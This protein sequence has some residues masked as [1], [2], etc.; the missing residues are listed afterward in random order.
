LRVVETRLASSINLLNGRFKVEVRYR[1]Q[2]DNNSEG[3][4]VG[5]SLSSS[6]TAQTAV[7][8]FGDPLVVELMVRLSDARPFRNNIDVYFGGIS[9]IAFTIKVTDLLTGTSR[10]YTKPAGQLLGG[11]DRGTFTAGVTGSTERMMQA[12][13]SGVVRPLATDTVNLLNGRYAVRMRYRNQ[14][15]NPATT[16]YMLGQSIAS[17]PTT[18]TAVFFFNSADVAEWLVRFSDARPFAER[19]DVFHGGL[20][21]IEYTIEVTDTQTGA[22]KEYPKPAFS[23][24]GFVDRQTFR[25]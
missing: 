9:D 21:D 2:F 24:L 14:F 23:F 7:F 17:S 6:S 5:E 10:E 15:A 12:M 22:T 4:L 3:S 16:G 25:P 8:T 11:V 1:N 18:E 19:I 13:R 20:S